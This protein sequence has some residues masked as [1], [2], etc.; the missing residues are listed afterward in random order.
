MASPLP[1]PGFARRSLAAGFAAAGAFRPRNA[2]PAADGSVNGSSGSHGHTSG[3]AR[4]P[5][6]AGAPAAEA[7]ASPAAAS[8]HSRQGSAADDAAVQDGSGN[9]SSGQHD[10]AENGTPR[11]APKMLARSKPASRC[12]LSLM[13]SEACHKHAPCAARAVLRS[14]LEADDH[15]VGSL[16]S[17]V[18]CPGCYRAAPSASPGRRGKPQH[19]SADT[20]AAPMQPQ[21]Q[22]EAGVHCHRGHSALWN[23]AAASSAG[24][25]QS[26]INMCWPSLEVECTNIITSDMGFAE[27]GFESA[28]SAGGG[29]ASA[30]SNT[31]SELAPSSASAAAAARALQLDARAAA[32]ASENAALRRSLAEAEAKRQVPRFS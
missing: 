21:A 2:P 13:L 9:I 6:V 32:V 18:A 12:G 17:C 28:D 1:A 8:A 11:H 31:S 27:D 26:F 23:H 20:E 10:S 30:A 25:K 3:V 16:S 7:T 29:Y 15:R 14:L 22:Q 19:K 5:L 24:R 4:E